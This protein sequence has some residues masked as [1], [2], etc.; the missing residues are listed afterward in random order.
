[1]RW[2][3]VVVSVAALVLTLGLLGMQLRSGQRQRASQQ[4]AH[5]RFMADLA[6]QNAERDQQLADHARRMADYERQ[7]ADWNL[8]QA[9]TIADMKSWIEQARA[10]PGQPLPPMPVVPPMPLP[11]SM[12][13]S[14]SSMP[15]SAVVSQP[16]DFYFWW[17]PTILL[18]LALAP[19]SVVEQQRRQKLQQYEEENQTCYSAEE[20]MENWEFKIMRCPIPMFEKPAFLESVLRE[21]ARAG[22]Q[23]VEKFDGMR[24]R[25]KRV[26]GRQPAADLPAGFDPY[27]TTVR[28][29]WEIHRVLWIFCILCL[30]LVPLFILL[31]LKDPISPPACL[32]LIGAAAGGAIV[33]GLF[34]VRQAAK[35]RRWATWSA[36]EL[37]PGT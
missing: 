26:A 3:H 32:A 30:L 20:L 2:L 28:W 18:P 4:A 12:P 14:T 29:K 36:E 13:F 11:P 5:D 17:F 24:V 37:F 19:I 21:E 10:R 33:F 6:R 31:Q 9:K 25:L 16:P 22:W 8:Q 27:R 7:R 35:Y 34:A 15:T 1:M 23:L